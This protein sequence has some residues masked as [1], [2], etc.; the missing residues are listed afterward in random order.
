M[1]IHFKFQD[2][3]SHMNRSGLSKIAG[4]WQKSPPTLCFWPATL[5]GYFSDSLVEDDNISHLLHNFLTTLLGPVQ[6]VSFLSIEMFYGPPSVCL[7]SSP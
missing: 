7:T 5:L 4:S 2:L 6:L 3:K 1:L